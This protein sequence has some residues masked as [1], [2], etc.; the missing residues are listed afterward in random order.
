MILSVTTGENAYEKDNK[1]QIT[2]GKMG[3]LL[4]YSAVGPAGKG[5]RKRAEK[6]RRCKRLSYKGSS[7]DQCA[8]K[9]TTK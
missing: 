3:Y 1:K 2:L 8:K 4:W 7:I 6:G 9:R 5:R